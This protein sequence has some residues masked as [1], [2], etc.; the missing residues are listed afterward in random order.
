MATFSKFVFNTASQN[1]P[2]IGTLAPKLSSEN[3]DVILVSTGVSYGGKTVT[4][5]LYNQ[6]AG[7]TASTITL[8][9]GNVIF[10]VDPKYHGS[11]FALYFADRSTTLFTV[12][13]A[14]TASQVVGAFSF[15]NRG[16]NERRRF[17]IEG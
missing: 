11:S 1:P 15:N 5:I 9:A 2:Q 17:A 4:G 6:V 10:M 3:N 7:T 12:N 16:P 8:S 13:T 14:A